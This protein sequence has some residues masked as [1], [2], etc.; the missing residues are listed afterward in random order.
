VRALFIAALAG[1][2]TVGWAV[3]AAAQLP[4]GEADGV[5]IVRE[6]GAIV[7]VFTKT[8][9][10]LL[11]RVAG[12]P[13][14]VY[15]TEFLEG[16]TASGEATVR[17]PKKGR[18]IRTGDLTRGMDYCRVWLAERTVRRRIRGK[19]RRVTRGRELIA[20]I[21]LTQRGAVYLDEQEK[22]GAL[23]GVLFLAQ[24]LADKQ[25]KDTIPTAEQILAARP[26]LRS[27]VVALMGPAETP[28]PDKV[29]YWSDGAEHV[30][31]V[32]LSTLGRRLFVEYEGDVLHTNVVEYIYGDPE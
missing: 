27:L 24:H 18:K 22:A 1:A 14:S 15:C 17:A 2:L 30:A 20:S 28:P 10:R 23:M 32:A 4:V 11:R 13:V 12:R 16:G 19:I 6:R 31:V 5:R 8:A 21:P 25:G 3:P 7:V 26:R 29:G 9:D